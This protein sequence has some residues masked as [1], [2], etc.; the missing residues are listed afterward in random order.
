MTGVKDARDDKER[1]V[2]GHSR[3]EHRLRG[4]DGIVREGRCEKCDW[5]LSRSCDCEQFVAAP[6]RPPQRKRNEPI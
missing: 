5:A 1:C 3:R 4:D 2:C 6:P